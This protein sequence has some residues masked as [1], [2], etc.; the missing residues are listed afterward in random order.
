MINGQAEELAY[1]GHPP[2][3]VMAAAEPRLKPALAM[4]AILGM[5]G[6]LWASLL[7]LFSV[8]IG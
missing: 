3:A 8:L 6:G 1:E 4:L 7:T 2:V 5:S